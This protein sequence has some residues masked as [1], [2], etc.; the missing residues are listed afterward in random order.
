MGRGMGGVKALEAAPLNSPEQSQ[1]YWLPET[2]EYVL[3]PESKVESLLPTPSSPGSS[4]T[5]IL[6]LGRKPANI[7]CAAPGRVVRAAEEG[8]S[9]ERSVPRTPVMS[10]G[11]HQAEREIFI[12][13]CIKTSISCGGTQALGCRCSYKNSKVGCPGSLSTLSH[14]GLAQSPRRSTGPG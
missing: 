6:A 11:K 2:P 14:A 13:F 7:G 8:L 12:V 10:G 9:R 5:E 3:P 4:S 1:E